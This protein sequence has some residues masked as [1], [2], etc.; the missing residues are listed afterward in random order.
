MSDVATVGIDLAKNV[1]AVHGVD[2]TG[3]VVLRRMVTRAKLLE[4]VARLPRCLIGME[5]C[6]GAHEWARRFLPFGHTVKLMSPSFVAPYRK[7]GKNDGND[8]EAICEAVSRPN[9]RFVPIK[10]AEQQ[11]ILTL[12]RVRQGFV[13]ERTATI[14]RIRGLLGEFGIV[15]GQKPSRLRKEIGPVLDA[16]PA[17]AR[18]TIDDLRSHLSALEA[19]LVDYDQEIR[20][21][22][23][24]EERSRRLQTIPGVGPTTASAIVASIGSGH[25]FKNG[26]Q[27]AAW[28]GLVP[29]Q[30]SSGGKNR[31]GRITKRGDGYLRTLLVLGARAVLANGKPPIDRVSRW[32]HSLRL[33]MSYHKVCVAIAAKNAR[34]IWALLARGGTYRAARA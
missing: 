23:Q 3:R 10:S 1:F 5:A 8:A 24:L 20:H 26:R 27:F 32:A 31:L 14:L 11:A 30:W 12:H 21:L 22:A 6:C 15:L 2:G 34:I 13:E 9:M 17:L 19:R 28:L 18:R 33:R 16:L 29:T 25:D 7:G 4:F